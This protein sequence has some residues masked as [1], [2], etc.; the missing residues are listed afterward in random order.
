MYRFAICCLMLCALAAAGD[1]K[2]ST[3]EADKQ[4][5]RDRCA[6]S[7]ES[8]MKNAKTTSQA[9]SCARSRDTCT[10]ACNK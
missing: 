10:G 7:F 5:C 9:T 4:K 8:C 3:S 6:K 2:S 1:K